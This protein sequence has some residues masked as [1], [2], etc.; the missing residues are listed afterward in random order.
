MSEIELRGLTKHYGK[1]S[2]A[3]TAVAD[4]SLTVNPG[5]LLAVLGPSGCGKTTTIRLTA[6][7]ERPTHGSVWIDHQEV[8]RVQPHRRHL[9]VVFQDLALYPQMTVFDNLAFSLQGQARKRRDIRQRILEVAEGLQIGGLLSRRPGTLSGGQSQRVALARAV[10][11]RP[12]GFLL[13][14]PLA[15]LDAPARVRMRAVIKGLLRDLGATALYVTHDQEEAMA[16][17]DR[18]AVL[19]GGRLVQ[20]GSGPQLF[21]KPLNRFVAGFV[22]VPSMNF[23]DG[24]L[25]STA[26]ACAVRTAAGEIRLARPPVRAPRG[27]DVLVGVRPQAIQLQPPGAGLDAR[28]ALLEY[29][30]STMNVHCVTHSGQPLLASVA[31]TPAWREQ[32]AVGLAIDPGQVMLFEADAQGL[33]LMQNVTE[34]APR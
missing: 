30:G 5:E 24:R 27:R 9:A 3:V 26:G 33:N 15:S 1:G 2:R 10:V 7:L 25:E 22:G 19:N 32:T 21:E 34:A 4:L 29:L 6:G 13:D 17:G 23:L 28:I 11:K 18:V 20:I 14:E 16:L 31:A 12:R 8:T